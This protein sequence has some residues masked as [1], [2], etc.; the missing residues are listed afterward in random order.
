MNSLSGSTSLAR[1]AFRMEVVGRMGKNYDPAKDQAAAQRAT[2]R[3]VRYE[4]ELL[5]AEYAKIMLERHISEA[6]NPKTDPALAAKLRESIMNRGIGRVRE[7]EDDST[8]KQK[9][10]GVVEFLET[11]AALSR[12]SGDTERTLAP[13]IERDISVVGTDEDIESYLSR[14]ADEDEGEDDEQP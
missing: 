4:T 12:S 9:G 11:L 6:L 5:A 13:R 2:L 7:A 3:R 1:P 8:T 10:A 14:L